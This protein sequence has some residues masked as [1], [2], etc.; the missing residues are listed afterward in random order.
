MK[1]VRIKVSEDT[2][3][4]FRALKVKLERETNEEM[5]VWMIDTITNLEEARDEDLRGDKSR[6]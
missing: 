1:H 6:T 4:K 2:Y 3:W 5:L